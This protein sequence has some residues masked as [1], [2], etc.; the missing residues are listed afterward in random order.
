MW[1]RWS[2]IC[3]RRL[4]TLHLPV[5][6]VVVAD[7]GMVTLQGGTVTLS[8]SADLSDFHTEGALLYPKPEADVRRPMRSS[9]PIR[10]LG[11]KSIVERMCRHICTSMR[12]RARATRSS[13]LP[14]RSHSV[15]MPSAPEAEG[16][17][18]HRGGHGFNPRTMPEMKAI[19]FAA[20]PDIRPGVQL[21][22]FENVNIYPFIAEILGLERPGRRWNARV[23]RPALKTPHDKR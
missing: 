1:T 12:T 13:C 11:S 16:A 2:E 21:K 14:G 22:P 18:K 15:R 20:G 4:L 9:W 19:F 8:D 3:G 5:D 17:I 6:F 7:H 23:L 10:I